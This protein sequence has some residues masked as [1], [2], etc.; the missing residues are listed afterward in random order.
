ML[1]VKSKFRCDL[2][3]KFRDYGVAETH[4]Q[5]GQETRVCALCVH[6]ADALLAEDASRDPDGNK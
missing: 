6:K 3:G 1:V 5:N 4:A 2:C